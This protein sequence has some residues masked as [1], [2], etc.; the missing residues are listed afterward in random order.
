[1]SDSDFALDV[2]KR[3]L[4][5]KGLSPYEGGSSSLPDFL[6]ADLDLGLI[7]IDVFFGDELESL[8]EKEIKI[9]RVKAIRNLREELG[10][11]ASQIEVRYLR[12]SVPSIPEALRTNEK[13]VLK[14]SVL[15]TFEPLPIPQELIDAAKNRFEPAFVFQGQV[16]ERSTE[17]GLHGAN[18]EQLRIRLDSAQRLASKLDEPFGFLRGVA[19]SGKTLVLVARAKYLKSLHP[20][21]VLRIVC[22]NKALKQLL[23]HQIGNLRGVTVETF[24]EYTV[25]TGDSFKQIGATEYNASRELTMF[26]GLGITKS[27]DA[28]LVDE[29][30]DFLPSWIEYLIE[31][32]RPSRGGI[33]VA[34][35]QN[36]A[37]YR[38]SDFKNIIAKY[39]FVEY[40]L[41]KPYRST[42]QILRVVQAL[43]PEVELTGIEESLDGPEPELIYV[44]SG[45]TVTNQAKAIYEDIK[46]LRANRENVKWSDF[47]ILFTL[48]AHLNGVTGEL[49]RLFK[50]DQNISNNLNPVFKGL[51]ET[52]DLGSD[53]IKLMTMASAK[54]LEFRYVLLVGLDRLADGFEEVQKNLSTEETIRQAR[55]N[56]VGPTRAKEQLNMYYAKDNVF[57]KRLTGKETLVRLRRYPEDYG[58]GGK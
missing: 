11:T 58:V 40:S 24:Y 46:Y 50:E 25:R 53:K 12:L 42:R 51:G 32:L 17:S 28:I 6:V 18:R 20:D 43:L 48:S 34:G 2:I 38:D 10:P 49:S 27:A 36:Q 3:S 37:L 23:S 31:T 16:R 15:D 7:A 21:W 19:G 56:L 8:S 41:G 33:L 35:D 9:R 29:V 22:F 52:L 57:L 47:G 30:Q 54:G 13:M 44:T 45:N 26:R 5:A 55:L 39:D 14:L 1:M 4:R